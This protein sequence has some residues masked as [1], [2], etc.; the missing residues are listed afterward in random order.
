MLGKHTDKMFW[1]Y[2]SFRNCFYQCYQWF[3]RVSE[4]K[5]EIKGSLFFQ[6]VFVFHFSTVPQEFS[7]LS[8]IILPYVIK[9]RQLL[10][11]Q[12]GRGSDNSL[13]LIQNKPKILSNCQFQNFIFVNKQRKLLSRSEVKSWFLDLG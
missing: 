10:K 7:L 6:N 13:N 8:L 5:T 11:S 1:D 12:I 3:L 2:T 9:N 4:D